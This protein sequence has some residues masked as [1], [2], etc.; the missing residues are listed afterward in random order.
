MK[1][2]VDFDYQVLRMNEGFTFSQLT[3]TDIK[4]YKK[5]MCE[6]GQKLAIVENMEFV[7]VEE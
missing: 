7:Y 3:E 4:Y 2:D 6:E 5:T 1:D